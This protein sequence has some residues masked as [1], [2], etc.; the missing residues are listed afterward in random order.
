MVDK[1]ALITGGSRGIGRGIAMALAADGYDLAISHWNDHIQ[2]EQVMQIISQ[3]PGRKCFIFYGNLENEAEP[4]RLVKEAIK[5]LGRIDV[6]VNNAGITIFND[7]KNME[8]QQMNKLM[9]LNLR[10]PLLLM[11]SVG[12]YMIQAGIHGS[13]INITSSRAERA[14][15]GDAVYGGLKAALARSVQ[16]IALEFSEYGIRVNCIAPGAISTTEERAAYFQKLGEK[17]PLKR[18]GMPEDIGQAAVWL[19]SDHSSYITGTT[20][21]VDGGLI[22]PG[23]PETI[24]NDIGWGRNSK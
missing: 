19:A 17:I 15:P 7:M 18:P 12:K 10:A 16:S 9:N 23:M 11:Q 22:L 1:T 5:A 4:D 2:A 13:M 14:Y 8:L 21:R 20:I 6:L 3:I 24:D